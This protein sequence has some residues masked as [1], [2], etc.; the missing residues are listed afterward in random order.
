M[1][2]ILIDLSLQDSP[3]KYRRPLIL[4]MEEH[5]PKHQIRVSPVKAPTCF[6][7]VGQLET[8]GMAG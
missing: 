1:E 5:W 8:E 2:S 6:L 3:D 7:P 4:A